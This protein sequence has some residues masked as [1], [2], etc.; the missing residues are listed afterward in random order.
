MGRLL[1]VYCNSPG[2]QRCIGSMGKKRSSAWL[3]CVPLS[4]PTLTPLPLPSPVRCFPYSQIQS[5]LAGGLELFLCW[6]SGGLG[7]GMHWKQPALVASA[8]P[9]H[10]LI[11]PP[12]THVS[13]SPKCVSSPGSSFGISG[14]FEKLSGAMEACTGV[15]LR[16]CNSR[17][18]HLP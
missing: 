2:I 17:G 5:L 14:P 1:G 10:S 18:S 9:L 12:N 4:P 3:L 7:L 13:L 8:E 16:T 15:H 11:L 6:Y